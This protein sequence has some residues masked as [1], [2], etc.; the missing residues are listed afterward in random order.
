VNDARD[1]GVRTECGGELVDQLVESAIDDELAGA[2]RHENS[3]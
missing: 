1:R 2:A 3:E